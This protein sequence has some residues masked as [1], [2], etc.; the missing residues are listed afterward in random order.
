MA[1]RYY[2]E[3]LFRNARNPSDTWKH[4]NQLLRKSIPK[5]SL[6]QTIKVEGKLISSLPTIYEE[7]NQHFISIGEKLRANQNQKFDKNYIKYLRNRQSSSII[8]RPTD[9]FDIVKTIAGMNIHKSPGHIDI[10]VILIKEA[11]FPFARFLARL[12][13][14]L[15][16]ENYTDSLKIAKVITLHKGIPNSISATIGLFP[17]YLQQTRYLKLFYSNVWLTFGKSIIF[18]PTISLV[19][20]NYIQLI[21]Q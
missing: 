2:F 7:L 17:F 16:T 11:K 18:L 13:N 4:L 9:V 6:P 19:S 5:S 15:E 1:K 14:D 21:L 3:N 12:F 8:L 20:E 10:P